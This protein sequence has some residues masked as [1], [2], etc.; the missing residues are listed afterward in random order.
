MELQK[1]RDYVRQRGEDER[2][3][4]KFSLKKLFMKGWRGWPETF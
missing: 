3:I 2:I 4:L 1:E